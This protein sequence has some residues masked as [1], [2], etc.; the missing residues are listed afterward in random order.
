MIEGLK[1]I[2]LDPGY[3]YRMA[4][5]LLELRNNN[6]KRGLLLNTA[7]RL[8]EISC[9]HPCNTEDRNVFLCDEEKEEVRALG[10]ALNDAGG[11]TLMQ[12]CCEFCRE[13]FM[14]RSDARF[15]EF[16]W[17]GIGDFSC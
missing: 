3:D 11:L 16:A 17:N 14:G 13:L 6:E 8:I 15:L 2:S 4:D 5:Q 1:I 10:T 9:N 12:F 7:T